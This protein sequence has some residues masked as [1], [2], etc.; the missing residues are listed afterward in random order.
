MEYLRGALSW[1]DLTIQQLVITLLIVVV[2]LLYKKIECLQLKYNQH[3]KLLYGHS[4]IIYQKLGVKTV[5]LHRNN[6]YEIV[7]QANED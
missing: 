1:V 4:I 5:K 6:D 7:Q 3:D 2:Y